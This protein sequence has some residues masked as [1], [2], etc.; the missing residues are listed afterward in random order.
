MRIT[1]MLFALLSL[2][3]VACDSEPTGPAPINPE[4]LNVG[5][6]G[7]LGKAMFG[8]AEQPG[9]KEDSLTRS[10]GPST[11]V[12]T[13]S[14][15]VW[16]VSASWTD[17]DTPAAKA[18]GIAW[19]ADS[20]LDWNQKFSAWVQDMRP[21]DGH[22]GYGTT[23]EMTTPWGKKLPAPALECAETAMFLKATF[24]SWYHLPFFVEAA[25][26]RRRIFLG[27]FGFIYQDGSRYG[28][29][30]AFKSRYKDYSDQAA[31]WESSWPK[32]DRLRGRKLGGS[33]DDF[34]PALFE[35]ARAGAYFDELYLNKRT[36]WFMIY[37]LSYF[38]SV[39]IADPRNTFNLDPRAIRAGD[40]LVERWQR[41]GIGH[42]F[43]TKSVEAISDGRIAA[44]V[45]SGS[46]PR[47]QPKWE[48]AGS[49][50][51]AYTNT[52]TGGPGES[53][54]DDGEPYAKLGGGLKRWRMAT[55]RNGKWT[56][57]VPPTDVESWIDSGDLE[58][59]ANRLQTFR[60]ILGELSIEE[61]R[62]IATEQIEAAREH[63]R[64]YPASCSARERRET[65]FE[66]LYDIEREA[67][68]SRANV[69][70]RARTLEDF[71]FAKLVYQ[72][73]RTC[74]WNSSTSGMYEMIMAKAQ[75]EVENHTTQMCAAPEVFKVT[76]GGY[77]TFKA[78]AA[79]VDRADEWVAWSA[80]ESCPQSGTDNDVIAE[81]GGASW[82]DVGE[83]I[84]TGGGGE[85]GETPDEDAFE[86][87]DSID[88]AADIEAGSHES[89]TQCG[90]DDVYRFEV[91]ESGEWTVRIEFTHNEGDLDLR[92]LKESGD[93][94][95][96]SAG[97]GNSEE[98]SAQLEAGTYF[99]EVILYG[100]GEGCQSYALELKH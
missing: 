94:I 20:G 50:Q 85:I 83:N 57:I 28:S 29:T 40:P 34:Q 32:D 33:Q 39:N 63:L 23:F 21:I 52:Y 58:A 71:V 25:D 44:E 13:G 16:E 70:A 12:D 74:C 75:G 18:A 82:C 61:R 41:T 69:D 35:G 65:A 14:A 79:S 47:R 45:V 96:A 9:A 31:S 93:R 6:E 37:L 36:G 84:L 80:D 11:S 95:D 56:N 24:A 27:H 2:A 66:K 81:H 38:G 54:G 49:S 90:D 10:P 17:T 59:I 46:M 99:A 78:Y 8:P 53:W 1:S 86:P 55:K 43:V 87:N 19:P 26:G 76:D 64:R 77:D 5:A 67:G 62:T 7:E 73:S 98:I 51:D 89:L 48:N 15:A 42:V 60:E 68:N 100:Q 92:L 88:A 4:S 22:N 30:P 91:A 3:L 72:E 97:T